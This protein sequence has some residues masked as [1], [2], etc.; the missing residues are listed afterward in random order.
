ML[1]IEYYKDIEIFKKD[2]D[3]N[4][5]VEFLQ[6][7][8]DIHMLNFTLDEIFR[9][10]DKKFETMYIIKNNVTIGIR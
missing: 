4:R 6:L 2:A 7:M 9:H 8:N 10:F 5:I 1:V 3:I